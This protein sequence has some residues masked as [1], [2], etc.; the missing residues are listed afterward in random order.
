MPPISKRS[1]FVDENTSRSLVSS[2]RAANFQAEHVY[3]A[4]LQGHPDSDIFAYAQAHKQT[5]ITADLDF[6][7]ITQYAPP[8]M[9]LSFYASQILSP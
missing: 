5:I 9:V 8:I 6:S 3:D 4:E 2:L 7:N 1:F